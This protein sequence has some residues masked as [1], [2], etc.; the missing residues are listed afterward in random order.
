MLEPK[1]TSGRSIMRGNASES[2][3]MVYSQR[4]DV[5]RLLLIVHT[6]LESLKKCISLYQA[7]SV[8]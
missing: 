6:I 8:S 1:T 3:Q 5:T 7:R 4:L 2:K